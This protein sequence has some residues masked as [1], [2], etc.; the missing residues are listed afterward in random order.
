MGRVL[1]RSF[2]LYGV[3]TT[4]HTASARAQRVQRGAFTGQPGPLR[5]VAA[6]SLRARTPLPQMAP[7]LAP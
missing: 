7:L 5:A 4:W 3:R 6:V 1:F 2:V